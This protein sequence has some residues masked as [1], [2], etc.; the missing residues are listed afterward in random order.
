MAFRDPLIH[1]IRIDVP[2]D[3]EHLPW[4]LIKKIC[5]TFPWAELGDIPTNDH[6]IRSIFLNVL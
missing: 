3:R 1:L 2:W 4:Y 6:Q 5:G